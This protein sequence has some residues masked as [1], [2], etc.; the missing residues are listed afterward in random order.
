MSL[1]DRE[2]NFEE[3]FK[4]GDRFVLM[5]LTFSGT[6]QTRVGKAERSVLTAVTR[7]SYPRQIAYSVLGVGFRAMAEQATESD[8]PVVVEYV[9]VPLAGGKEVKRLARVM[10]GETPLTPMDYV[11]NSV[12][13]DP[14]DLSQFQSSA[15]SGQ[16]PGGDG[17][18]F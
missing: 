4:V 2:P 15:D 17:P 11:H 12:D 6:I 16:V 1:F 13:G 9:R 5:N 14:I 3:H 18:G 10:N 7:D 8:F